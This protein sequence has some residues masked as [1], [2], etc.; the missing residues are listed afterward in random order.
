MLDLLL[1]PIAVTY[2][3]VVGVLFIYG[4]NFFYLTYLAWKRGAER[5]ESPPMSVWPRV[6]VQLPIYN[7]LYV[8]ERLID[9]VARLDYPTHLLDIQVLDDSTDETTEV[10][11][12]VVERLRARGIEICHLRRQNRSGFKAGALAHGLLTARGEFLAMFDADFIPPPD[13]LKRTLPYFQNPCIAFIQTRWG[14]VNR[15]YSFLTF[16][17]SLAIDAHF[18]VEQCADRKS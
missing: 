15:D 14:H 8:A 7:E 4:L 13:F 9:A 17:Q 11:R 10:V 6:T 3:I 5:L 12:R 18:M 16:L 2:L 1:V